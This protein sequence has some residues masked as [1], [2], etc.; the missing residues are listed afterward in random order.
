MS[1]RNIKLV[2]GIL[3]PPGSELTTLVRDEERWAALRATL[4]PIVEPGCHFA[5][6]A[7]GQ[8]FEYTGLNGLREGWL[9]WFTP[10]TSYYSDTEAVLDAGDQVVVLVRDRGQLRDTDAKVEMLG[11]GVCSL[12]DGKLVRIDFYAS[13]AEAFD[14]AGLRERSVH[15]ESS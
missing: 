14:A 13:R 1:Q 10:W 15:A 2:R 4:E 5:W 3:A 6:I 12:R 9:E 11:A 8:R 7:W